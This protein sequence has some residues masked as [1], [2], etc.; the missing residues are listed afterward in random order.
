MILLDGHHLTIAAVAVS[1]AVMSRWPGPAAASRRWK[2][3]AN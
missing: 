2:P 1:V 3:A